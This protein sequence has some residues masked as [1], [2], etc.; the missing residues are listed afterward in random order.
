MWSPDIT[1]DGGWPL[2]VA[3]ETKQPS[4]YVAVLAQAFLLAPEM[5]LEEDVLRALFLQ[6]ARAEGIDGDA[7]LEAASARLKAEGLLP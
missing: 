1:H 6:H 4:A 5:A 2:P 7:L 3:A